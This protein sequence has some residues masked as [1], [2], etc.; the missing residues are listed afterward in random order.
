MSGRSRNCRGCLSRTEHGSVSTLRST[1]LIQNRAGFFC[2][3]GG[4]C[5]SISVGRYRSVL[6]LLVEDRVFRARGHDSEVREQVGFVVPLLRF[7]QLQI[8]IRQALR[9][10]LAQT[11]E[12]FERLFPERQRDRQILVL[13]GL[14]DEC[15][16]LVDARIVFPQRFLFVRD[17]CVVFRDA[18]RQAGVFA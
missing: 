6:R 5:V 7:F 18:I 15:T 4:G 10:L 3:R 12:A 2:A 9:V 8:E 14:Q 11:A 1:L 16:R 13:L 17:D